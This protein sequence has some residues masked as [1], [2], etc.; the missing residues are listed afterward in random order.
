MRC[1]RIAGLGLGLIVGLSLTAIARAGELEKEDSA[2]KSSTGGSWWNGWFGTK[3]KKQEAKAGN[4][5]VK[6]TSIVKDNLKT[7]TAAEE[8]SRERTTLLRRLAVCDQ[9]RLIAAQ[10]N[11]D[12]LAKK[13]DQL[14]ERCWQIYTERL[15]ALAANPVTSREG[16][17]EGKDPK[18]RSSKS[19]EAVRHEPKPRSSSLEL[20]R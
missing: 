18:D 13:A 10:K 12:V 4:E 9:L 16:S 6:G 2:G 3:N 11:D 8:R 15:A 1:A 14:D 20:I 17:N 5:P 19:T 7:D